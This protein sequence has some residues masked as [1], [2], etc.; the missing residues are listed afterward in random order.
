MNTTGSTVAA[1][2]GLLPR[3]DGGDIHARPATTEP[4]THSA[5][6]RYRREIDGLRAVAV[7]LVILYHAE[8]RIGP[9]DPFVGGF[10][11]VDIFFVISGYLIGLIL[12]R[13]MGESRFSLLVF[14]ERRARR[15]LPALYIVLLAMLPAAWLLMLPEAMKTFGATL[16]S[17]VASASNIFFWHEVSYDAPDNLLNPLIHSWSLGLEEQFYLLFPA[18][19][20]IA[21]RFARRWMFPL[22][23]GLCLLSLVLA[24]FMTR[25]APEASFFLLPSRMWELGLGALLAYSE[26]NARA[27]ARPSRIWSAIG[28]AAILTA[29]PLMSVHSHHPGLAT[30]VPVIGTAL[31]IRYATPSEGVGRWL[32]SPFMVGIGLISY[33]LYLWHQ[34]VFAF[35]RLYR[36]DAATAAIKIEWIAL[37][38]LLAIMTFLLV[39]RPTRN[40]KRVSSRT[41]WIMAAG[42][43]LLLATAGILLY[44][45]DGVPGRFRGPLAA[46][47]KAEQIDEAKLF[48]NGRGCLN[49]VPEKGPCTF[50]KPGSRGLHLILAGDSHART[51]SRSLVDQLPR[52]DALASVTLLNRGGCLMLPGLTRVDDG[53]PSCPDSYNRDRMRYLLAQPNAV[54]V[55]MMRLPVLMEKSRFDN[56]LGGIEPGAAPYIASATGPFDAAVDPAQIQARLSET[57]KQLLDAGVKV[58]LVYPVPEMG[59]NIPLKLLAVARDRPVGDWLSPLQATVS[60]AQF[61]SRS[62][63]SYALLDSLGEHPGLA[64]VYP[65]QSL[66]RATRCLSHEGTSIWYRDDNHLT[67]EGADRVTKALIQTIAQRWGGD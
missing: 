18:M 33:S 50:T 41:I 6:L 34:P 14:Y 44:R 45:M 10:I 65:E 23:C 5:K 7:V 47:A 54:A 39:E 28:L 32:A 58:V 9:V 1:R 24:E 56:G 20:L 53:Q 27:P 55:L 30:V 25:H 17:A 36:P 60:R 61:R 40:R 21:H 29:V 37:S 63:S 57:V 26:L 13:E 15:I 43:A 64:R 8:V 12:L 51:L 3:L 66:C 4:T 48:Q 19:L 2:E 52:T 62:R 67:R 11:G 42:G 38:V 46:I 49:Y 16:T 31:L 35:G 59:W 22:L